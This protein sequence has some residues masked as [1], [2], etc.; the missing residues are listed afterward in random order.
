MIHTIDLKF[1]G[2]SDNIAA[3]V[4]ESPDGPIL[5]ETG[6]HSTLP[7]LR[8]GIAAAGFRAEDIRHVFLTHIHLD[9][10]G[11]A[12]WF[13]RQGAQ[14]YVHPKGARHLASP[15]RLMESARRIYQEQMDTLWGEMHPIPAEQITEVAD[16]QAIELGGGTHMRAHHTPGHA[17]H[18]IAWQWG[19]QLFT[20]DVAGVRIHGGMVIPPCPPPDINLEDWKQSIERI[21]TLAP[22]ELYLTHFGPYPYEVSHLDELAA[23]LIRWADWMRP[24]YEAGQ[25]VT[26]VTPKFQQMVKREMEESGL[27]KAE[28]AQYEAAN[29]GW[30]SV[31]GLLRYWKVTTD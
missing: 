23:R 31:A 2:L 21:K 8:A 16:Q 6:P 10:A 9:H 18:H 24:Y 19:D 1:Q 25:S 7:Q 27:T 28:I 30:M 17:V 14:I 22:R 20:G 15:E 12:W 5:V 13:A 11:S 26:E 29:P 3:F 4:V